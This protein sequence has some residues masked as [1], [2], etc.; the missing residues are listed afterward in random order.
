MYF[1]TDNFSNL[2]I[3]DGAP[4]LF[5][6]ALPLFSGLGDLFI[7]IAAEPA[8][9]VSLYTV[10][11]FPEG[12][13]VFLPAF[14]AESLVNPP[15]IR[16][17]AQT[18]ALM[19]FHAPS[20]DFFAFN[21][22]HPQARQAAAVLKA[23]RKDMSLLAGFLRTGDKAAGGDL[24]RLAAGEFAMG[25]MHGAHYLYSIAAARS[26]AS[27]ARFALGFV[28]VELGL[29]Q[30]AYDELKADTDPEARL[31][32]AVIH[33]K[34]GNQQQAREL[35]SSLGQGT[36]LN[37]KIAIETA[38]LD[39]ESAP[40]EA[41]RNFQRLTSSSFDKIE[42]LSGLGAAMSRNAF[43]TKDKGRLAAAANALRSA[44]STPSPAS[45]RI[46]FQLGNLYFR[47]G[48]LAQAES[49]YRRSSVLAPAVQ[50]LANLALTLIKTGKLAEA[51]QLTSQIALTDIASAKRLAAEFP[52][53]QA[54]ALFQPPRVEAAPVPPAARPQEPEK[55][56]PPPADALS[57]PPPA[58]HEQPPPK[59]APPAP[60][61]PRPASGG[62]ESSG[63]GFQFINPAAAR[64]PETSQQTAGL[65]P[66]KPR[67]SSA[68]GRTAGPRS[69]AP[70][71]EIQIET[72]RDVM[73]AP[74]APTEDD[75]RKDDFISRAFRLASDLE[76]EFGK[77]IYFNMDGLS[78]VERKLRLTF[79][80]AKSTPQG[81]SQ[82]NIEAVMNSAAFLCY[83]LQERNK[84][85]LIK[86]PDFDPWGWP[87][88][89]E[90]PQTKI[91]TYPIQRVWRMLWEETVPEPGWLAKYADWITG[92]L[93]STAA[94]PCGAAAAKAKVTSHPERIADA[95]TEHKRMLV[96]ASSLAET[97]N[98]EIARTG[99]IKIEN[100]IKASF[101]PEIPPTTDGWKILRC[102]GHLFAAI[103]AKEFKTVW[104]NADGEDGGW[105]MRLPWKTMVFPI[106]KI[107]KTAS[108]RGDL[109]SY[110][111]EIMAEKLRY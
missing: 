16:Q 4:A 19:F 50:A 66:A 32:L 40:E 71:R 59:T 106:G 41:E 85:H 87:M 91:T 104:F 28:L 70:P 13:Q 31:C 69:A 8:G 7:P 88:I 57:Q 1:V 80:K 60:V 51:A 43:R 12:G 82:G 97:S 14:T 10:P 42:A 18:S 44:L 21:P 102:Y 27:R 101:R 99:I 103:L 83:F 65:S 110:Y 74:G 39:L 105:S 29:L 6:D 53:E 35:L 37:E 48:E 25:N 76:D 100:A 46:F 47:S 111:E 64:S 9:L 58:A 75:S 34:T 62:L 107:Y 17:V 5:R 23:S 72:L 81:N 68:S 45:G 94:A 78:E 84:G 26:P 98:I 52:K 73:F 61:S 56:E 89:F 55:K 77:K 22:A 54:A 93:R 33:R 2:N 95:Q 15:F 96:L 49:C 3:F 30:E 92:R 20:A 11:P 36:Q 38:W 86:L 108:I 109:S 24:A 90:L 67:D 63:A 79:I